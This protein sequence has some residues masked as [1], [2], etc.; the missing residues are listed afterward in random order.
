MAR[1]AGLGLISVTDHDTLGGLSAKRDAAER[2]GLLFVGGWEVSSYDGDRKVHVLG[3]RCT[4]NGAYRDFAEARRKD[5]LERAEEI[6][7]RGNAELGLSLTVED[8]EREH[9]RKETPI[10]TMHVVRAFAKKLGRDEGELYRATFGYGKPAY[11]APCRA[12]TPEQAVGLVLGTGGIPVLAHPGR[13]PMGEEELDS[14]I[15]RLVRCGLRGIECVYT[16][17]TASETAR[18]RR[19]AEELGLLVTGGSDY[20]GTDG[21]H[22]IGEPPFEPGEALLDALGA[23]CGGA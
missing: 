17:H 21:Y 5:A 8:A 15:L 9:L 1:E 6:L 4:E 3:Y 12:L 13:I 18:F 14:L 22:K 16:E 2:E 23:P 7:K 11:I 20:H 10:H 19:M